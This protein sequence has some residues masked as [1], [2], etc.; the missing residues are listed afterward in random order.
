MACLFLFIGLY[1]A[2]A[3]AYTNIPADLTLYPYICS[4]SA[5]SSVKLIHASSIADSLQFRCFR[6][7]AK[8]PVQIAVRY[9]MH[10][11]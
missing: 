8:N 4:T 6:K 2:E 1:S 7:L 3:I 11:L 9:L 5:K 10:I